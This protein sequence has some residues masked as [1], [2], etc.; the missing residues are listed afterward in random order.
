M[1]ILYNTYQLC[2]LILS[3]SY[4]DCMHYDV[5]DTRRA[6]DASVQAWVTCAPQASHEQVWTVCSPYNQSEL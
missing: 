2:D 5:I 4:H 3:L 6:C 1:I